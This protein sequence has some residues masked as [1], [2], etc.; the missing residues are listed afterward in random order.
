M[1]ERE[2]NREEDGSERRKH[3]AIMEQEAIWED[4]NI[5]KLPNVKAKYP[6]TG[7]TGS[8]SRRRREKPGNVRRWK[9]VTSGN[10][11]IRSGS[12]G[13][14]ASPEMSEPE[15]ESNRKR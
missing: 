5:R 11:R 15:D 1:M 13:R 14:R 12:G 6:E 4:R 10:D 7:G 8:E 3:P 2:T 9:T